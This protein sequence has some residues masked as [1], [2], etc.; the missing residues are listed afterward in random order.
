MSRPDVELM[1][2]AILSPRT[3]LG[4]EFVDGVFALTEGNPFFTEEILAVLAE[5][6]PLSQLVL[7]QSSID[8]LRI[9][10]SVHDAVVRRLARVSPA[11]QRVARLGAVAG[12]GFDFAL[13]QTLT[14]LDEADLL[15]SVEELVGVHLLVEESSERLVFRHA[16][17]RQAIYAQLLARERQALHASVVQAMELLCGASTATSHLADLAYHAYAARDWT[18]VREYSAR[19]GDRALRMDAPALAVEHFGR[20]LEAARALGEA[21]SE[22]LHRA[23]GQAYEVRGEFEPAVADY[24]AA[25]EAARADGDRGGEWQGLLDLGIAWLARD[26]ARAGPF[27]DQALTLAGQLGDARQIAYSLN[28]LGNWYVNLDEPDRGLELHERALGTFGELGDPGGVAETLDF[29]GVASLIRGRRRAAIATLEQ[30]TAAYRQVNDRRGLASVLATLAH[31]R[32]TSHVYDMLPGAA[33]AS[34]QS[35]AEVAEALA[36]ARTIGSRSAEAYAASELAACLT[37]DGQFGAALMAVRE[38][39]SIAEELEHGPWLAI[40]HAN[41]GMIALDLLD[42][43]LARAAFERSYHAAQVTGV[44]HVANISAALLARAMVLGQDLV[45][46]EALLRQHVAPSAEVGGLTR[47]SLLAV[48]A[49][50]RLVQGAASEALAI[51]ERLI[52]WA[53]SSGD[54]A[55]ARLQ[56]LH[57]ECQAVLGQAEVAEGS[58]RGALASAL[59]THNQP[60]LWQVHLSLGRLLQAQARR[61]EASNEYAAAQAVVAELTSTL[62]D[63]PTRQDFAARAA[64]QLPAARTP[65]AARLAR[66]TNDGLTLRERDV[67]ALIGRGLSNADIAERLVISERTVESHT[68]R[69]YAKLRC[70]S[71]SQVTAWAIAR[72]LSILPTNC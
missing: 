43:P 71:R 61:R 17:T 11:A 27:F 49:E 67:A 9:P 44:T 16:L 33:P 12:R 62:P 50:L 25:L 45:G 47:A 7:D 69:I 2:G 24:R 52:A 5:T 32:S 59:A 36:M 55:P 39:Q 53:A 26:Y 64:K 37:A 20:A 46:A 18:R 28:R 15:R 65:S 66:D 60:R 8:A 35:L 58:L 68:G 57:G 38:S 30:A 70:T 63:G 14:Q 10:R 41:S 1:A 72:G 6:D 54:G 34:E 13:L 22:Q 23:R 56:H 29:V 31:L 51:A 40:A 21:P 4:A 3:A 42:A 19:M 48:Y